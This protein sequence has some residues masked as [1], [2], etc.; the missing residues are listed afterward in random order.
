MKKYALY[1]LATIVFVASLSAQDLTSY[2]HYLANPVQVDSLTRVNATVRVVEHDIPTANPTAT[3]AAINGHRIMIFMSNS[4]TARPDA[5]AAHDLF[6]SLFPDQ[7]SYITYENPYFKVTVG[8]YTSQEEALIQLER[9][10]AS[11]PKAFI[12]RESIVLEE[13]TR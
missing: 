11:F 12:V 6:V 2:K 3:T 13:L 5:L 7:C 10:K 1:G 4:A 9:I 8:N